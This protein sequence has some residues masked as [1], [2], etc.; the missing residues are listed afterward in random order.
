MIEG[1]N[2][3]TNPAHISSYFFTHTV[4]QINPGSSL[5]TIETMFWG[6]RT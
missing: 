3:F 4:E 5:D 2:K 6:D 1:K